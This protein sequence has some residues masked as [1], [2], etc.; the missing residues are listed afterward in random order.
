MEPSD[1]KDRFDEIAARLWAAR[2][3]LE[4]LYPALTRP[5]DQKALRDMLTDLTW[6]CENC[7]VIGSHQVGEALGDNMGTGCWPEK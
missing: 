4:Q 3:E 6:A 5:D 2:G 1:L 7:S